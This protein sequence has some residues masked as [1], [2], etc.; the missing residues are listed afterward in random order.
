[1]PVSPE[2]IELLERSYAAFNARKVDE[3]LA[4]MRPDIDWPDMLGNR[5][6]VGR[7]AVREY[8]QSQ[9]DVMDPNVTPTGYAEG[10]DG[11]VVVDVHQVVRDKQGNLLGEQDVQHAYVF[12]D[13]LAAAMDVYQGGQLASAPRTSSLR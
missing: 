8:W 2:T 3:A 4:T 5:R 12:R 1:M 10:R 11:Q 9:F 7:D 13:G 6:I